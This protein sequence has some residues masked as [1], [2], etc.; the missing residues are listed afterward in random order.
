MRETVYLRVTQ[1]KTRPTHFY[2]TVRDAAGKV[3]LE[4]F[5][6]WTR[7]RVAEAAKEGL[8]REYPGRKFRLVVRRETE[9]F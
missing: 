8:A 7:K 5:Q 6:C 9:F 1:W 4:V 3:V 2:G